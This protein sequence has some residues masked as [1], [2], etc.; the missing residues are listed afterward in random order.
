MKETVAKFDSALTGVRAELD[1]MGRAQQRV[2]SE[3]QRVEEALQRLQKEILKDL[4]DG[5]QEVKQTRQRDFSSLEQAVEERLAELST[6]IGD[7][8][9]G[10][11]EVQG[12][13]QS[14]LQDLRVR[15]EGLAN[16]EKFRQELQS[17]ADSMI[18]LQVDSMVVEK[19]TNSLAEQ[20]VAVGAE[21]Q[22]RNQEVASQS[23][24]IVS[25]RELVQS[26]IGTLRQ[27]VSAVEVSFQTLSDQAQSIQ[28]GLLQ[29]EGSLQ[30]LEKELR[31]SL[32]RAER[33]SEELEARV[34]V[35][36]ESID[37]VQV[38]V[39]EQVAKLESSLAKI[40]FHDSTLATLT[41]DFEGG[42]ENA[43]QRAQQLQVILEEMTHCQAL[44]NQAEALKNDMEELKSTVP[45]LDNAQA[46]L[47]SA[48]SSLSQRLDALEQTLNTLRETITESQVSNELR[49]SL[50]QVPNDMQQLRIAVDNLV[51]YS[52][53]VEKHEEAI[54]S[55]QKDLEKTQT[56]VDVLFKAPVSPEWKE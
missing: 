40:D 15:L 44:G 56:T 23:Q 38:S 49:A 47:A 22:T 30:S 52:V 55:M 33:N 48:H 28:T 26:T 18:K 41:K 31:G 5:I 6:S 4:S 45:A 36:E 17:L 37:S 12:E 53:K 14:Q 32:D 13:T 29:A 46:E 35:L 8:V 27:S 24:E 2:E 50:S 10:V 3:T 20:I 1:T 34:K 11:A 21:L 43:E 51:A 54:Y 16:P 7:S 42:R 19:T 25:V 39:A 9:A